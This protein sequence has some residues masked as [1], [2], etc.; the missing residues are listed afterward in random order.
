MSLCCAYGCLR[1]Q[2]TL[3]WQALLAI[4]KLV[5]IIQANRVS[6]RAPCLG[7][8]KWSNQTSAY[9][10]QP[11]YSFRH[12]HSSPKVSSIVSSLFAAKIA[13]FDSL[14]GQ[15]AIEIG[16]PF[17]EIVRLDQFLYRSFLHV[18]KKLST[19]VENEVKRVSHCSAINNYWL[20]YCE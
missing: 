16:F 20:V 17:K 14:P 12:C 3:N 4:D 18:R 7:Y 13:T 5:A 2:N 15:R 9:K 1:N 6:T 8:Q 11:F 10:G 19:K